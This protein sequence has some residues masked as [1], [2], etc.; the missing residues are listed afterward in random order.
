MPSAGVTQFIG[1]YTPFSSTPVTNPAGVTTI[2]YGHIVQPGESFPTPLTPNQGQQLLGQDLGQAAAKVNQAV[3]AP[4]TQNQFDALTAYTQGT[5]SIQ[6]A[7]FLSALNKG[8]YSAA[9]QVLA[10]SSVASGGQISPTLQTIRVNQA[11]LF[12]TPA[13]S[14][15]LYQGSSA[16]LNIPST[17]TVINGDGSMPAN[18]WKGT[19]SPNYA[20]AQQNLTNLANNNLNTSNLGQSFLQAQSAMITATQQAIQQMANTPPLKMLV[21]PTSFKLSA[22]KI[23]ADGDWGRNGPIVEQWGEAQDK[24]EASGKVAAFYSLDVGGTGAA[25]GV[26]G[27]PGITRIA[28]QYSAAYQNFLSLWLLYKNNGALWINP[29]AFSP[30]SPNTGTASP[31]ASQATNL[32]VLGSI[33]LYYDNILYIGSFDNFNLTE[34]ETAPYTLE[35][36]FSFTVRATFLLDNTDDLSLQLSGLAQSQLNPLA[37]IPSPNQIGTSPSVA[38]L[39][40]Q[41]GQ[42]AG[43]VNPPPGLSPQ[44]YTQSGVGAPGVSVN[45]FTNR[46]R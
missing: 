1:S 42:P 46:P 8:N 24:L 43:Q 16:T 7:P 31:A 35:Y 14:S 34:S 3:T 15:Y 39:L 21:N 44:Q 36:N 33:Y 6:N 32:S 19:G 45:S 26:Y 10:Q 5:G 4:L 28:R 29:M 38:A 17:S 37:G 41:N 12:A 30:M 25:G 27:G 18:Q 23:I 13:G 2:G 11:N 40:S 20:Q 22:E 9:T